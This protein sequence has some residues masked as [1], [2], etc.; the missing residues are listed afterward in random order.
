[1]CWP[2]RR[3]VG[4]PFCYYWHSTS[5]LL[6]SVLSL[7]R[8]SKR[9]LRFRPVCFFQVQHVLFNPTKMSQCDSRLYPVCPLP[10]QELEHCLSALSFKSVPCNGFQCAACKQAGDIFFVLG[11]RLKW[12]TWIMG[13]KS[14]RSCIADYPAVFKKNIAY[15]RSMSV[16]VFSCPVFFDVFYDVLCC[17]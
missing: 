7:K 12:C 15:M 6:P 2:R 9:W 3:S 5:T 4:K 14:P 16:Y 11:F 17:L 13:M 8:R 10:P 1:M